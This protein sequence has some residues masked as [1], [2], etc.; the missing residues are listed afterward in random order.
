MCPQTAEGMTCAEMAQFAM[1]LEV[2][3]SQKPGNIDRCHDYEDTRLQHFLASAVLAGPVFADVEAGR[4]SIGEAMKAAVART[5]MHNGGNTHFGAF[6]LL[7]PLIAG[8]GVAGAAEVV[9]RTTVSDAVRFY[10][11]FG[12]T[13]VRVRDEDPMD[14]HDPASV[15]MLEEKGMTM[16]DV[17]VYS[18][19]HDMV[20]REWTN[21]FAL[22]REAADILHELGP[23]SEN[24]SRMF[25]RLLA[26]Y[27]DTF[28]VKKFDEG[29]AVRVMR[30]A[31]RVLAGECSLAAFD[32]DCIAEGINPGSLA[33]IC[34]AGIFT[35]LLEGWKWDW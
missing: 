16:Y 26:V 8:K 35:A 25:L 12:L 31:G 34:I 29:T 3:A 2:S 5:N 22:T 13:Q 24:I 32:A 27:P 20:A 23:G 15:R 9:R 19:S 33:D 1:L 28:V 7:F 4:L 6:I 30:Q 21:G 14:V 18:A 10:E 11:A 17:M